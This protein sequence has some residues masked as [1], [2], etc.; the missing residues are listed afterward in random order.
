MRLATLFRERRRAPRRPSASAARARSIP[1]IRVAATSAAIL[2]D[3]S[4]SGA[5]LRTAR[6]PEPGSQVLLE[7]DRLGFFLCRVVRHLDDGIAV[8]FE[9]ATFPEADPPARES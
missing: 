4:K 2:A 6:R 5:A 3:V 8:R 9:R 1:S 7:I